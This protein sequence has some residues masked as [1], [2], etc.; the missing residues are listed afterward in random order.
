MTRM[1]RDYNTLNSLYRSHWIVRRII[2]TI[3]E[4]MCRNFL[5]IHSDLQPDDISKID[6]A[7]KKNGL[8][9]KILHGLKWGRLYGGAVGIIMIDGHEDILDEPLDIDDVMPGAFAGLA[10]VDRWTGAYPSLEI[11]ED[12]NDPEFGLPQYYNVTMEGGELLKIHH[13]RIIR[14]IGRKL[15]YWEELAETHWG[16]SEVEVVFDELRKRDTVSWN[17]AQLVFLANLRV[18]KMSDLGEVLAVGNAAAQQDLYNTLQAQNWLQSNMGVYVMGKEDG[19]ETHEYSFS[20]LDDIY[21]SFMMDVAGACQIP[22]TK[23]FGRSPDGM[24]ATGESDM[25]NYYETIQEAQDS[26]L[27]PIIDKLLPIICMSEFGQLIDDLEYSFNPIRTPSDKETADLSAKKTTAILDVFNAG[28]ISQKTA[29][30]ELKQ[31]SNITGLFTN[32]TD[33]DI[34]KADDTTTPGED[35][36]G[37]MYGLSAVPSEEK[38]RTSV[39]KGNPT[40]D[41]RSSWIARF[42][43]RSI[44]NRF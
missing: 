11:I 32:I 7:W 10:I 15:P 37:D 40:N 16:A 41:G 43:D 27:A 19:F 44:R 29:L 34:E 31:M 42:F 9:S 21:E 24:N 35:M 17:I 30:M 28:V 1:T 22:V 12:I 38:D 5:T 26:T 6:K 33:E 20:G 3:P 4:D 25:Q 18:L 23:L 39:P 14:F 36:S 8:K 2:D 13:S